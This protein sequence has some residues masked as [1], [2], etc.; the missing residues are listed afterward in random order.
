M[1][2]WEL[3]MHLCDAARKGYSLSSR[4]VYIADQEG[5]LWEIEGTGEANLPRRDKAITLVK[6]EPKPSENLHT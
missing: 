3:I 4:E 6:G 5:H 1:T 2:V